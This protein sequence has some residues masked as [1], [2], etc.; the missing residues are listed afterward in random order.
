[1]MIKVTSTH[2]QTLPVAVQSDY[3]DIKDDDY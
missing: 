2:S 1:M 3:G